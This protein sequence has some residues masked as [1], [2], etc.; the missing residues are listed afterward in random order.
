MPSLTPWRP[1][2]VSL[3]AL[4]CPAAGY[5]DD[6][7]KP[8]Y[9]GIHVIDASTGR[10]APLVELRTV[11][12]IALYTDSAGWIAF[13]E[14]GLMEREVF[15][16]VRSPGYEIDKDGFGF[17][18]VR[19]ITKAGT[20]ATVKI[21]RTNI[22]ERLY[23]VTGEGIYR[24]SVLLGLTTPLPETNAAVL[25]Q[26]SVQAVPYRGKLFWLWG[27]T[28]VA[29]YP[30]GN[31]KTTAATAPLPGAK[32][33]RP[34]QGVVFSYYMTS[35]LDKPKAP[36]DKETVRAM[37]PFKEPG[38]VWLF[39]LLN[40]PDEKGRETLLA[41]FS[42]RK[43]LAEEL[44][45][46][47]VR[48]DDEAGVFVKIKTLDKDDTWRFPSHNAVRVNED[49]GD[50]FY[51]AA[52]LCHTRVK[53]TLAAI[54]DPATYEALAFDAKQ[55]KYV[56]QREQRPTT[57]DQERKLVE[58]G[59]MKPEQARWTIVDAASGKRVV[60]HGGS[61]AWNEFRK[62][63]VLIAVE[64]GGKGAPSLLGEVWYA[65]AARPDGPWRQ[66][67]KVASHPNYSFYNPR[68]H[69]FFDEDGGRV[70]YFEGT[71]TRT[72]SGNPVATPRYEYNQLMYRLDLA[73]K[74]LE[75]A[76]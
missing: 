62:K 28:N 41:H 19:L 65:E 7:I 2:A 36:L 30:L 66:A 9:F 18:G 14:P 64:R 13:H 37:A 34:D 38:V 42:R 11:N 10:G 1:V 48:F 60:F 72:F 51:F 22:A 53:A 54:L 12:D 74:R 20:S 23:R 52:P 16:A 67:I 35:R 31:F 6:K 33:T 61:V 43:G 69:A 26:D 40:V 55:G 39:G 68:H 70:I 45:H 76:R 17:R 44:E 73:D 4:C 46:G 27:D 24:D 71:Y 63:W 21:K 8:P 50:Y 57:Q 5:G 15:F 56:W 25:G 58:T 3:A 75:A 59:V 49:D 32:G 29:R 47:L